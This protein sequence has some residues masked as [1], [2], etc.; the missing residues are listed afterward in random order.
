[1]SPQNRV[2]IIGLDGASLNVVLPFAQKGIMP[3][4]KHVIDRGAVGPLRSVTPPVTGPAWA[5]FLTGKQPGKHG[6]Y[7]FV[8]CVPGHVTRKP[9]NYTDIKSPTLLSLVGNAK[10]KS[11]CSFNVPIT[12]P[13]P[14]I[15]GIVVTGMLTPDTQ[16]EFTYPAELKNKLQAKYGPYILDVFWQRFSDSTAEKFVQQLMDYERQKLAIAKDLFLE[17]P[18]DLF[19]AVFTG[20]DRIQHALWHVIEAIVEGKTLSPGE[21]RLKPLVKGYYRLLDEGIADLI[22]ASDDDTIIFFMSDHGFGPLRKKFYI[23]SWLRKEGLLHYDL[24]QARRNTRKISLK[25][26]IKQHLMR[27]PGLGQLLTRPVFLP[28]KGRMQTYQF[29]DLIDWSRTQA[30]SASNTEQGIYVNLKGRQPHGVVNPGK[31]YETLRCQI[32][33]MLCGIIDPSD[34]QPLVSHIY[35]KEDIYI[36]PYTESA[37]DIVF[38]L[39]NGECLADVRLFDEL[40]QET[41]WITGRG[42]HRQDG[43]FIA[44][45]KGIRKDISVKA[46]ITDLVPIVLYLLEIPIPHEVD[47]VLPISIFKED[48]LQLRAPHYETLTAAKE[49]TV[50]EVF[51]FTDEEEKKIFQKLKGLGYMG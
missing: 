9:V 39:K 2:M 36:G 42:T 46:S 31:D 50:D 17:R 1:M 35:K 32:I 47:G 5:S 26:A 10:G 33:D 21:E 19:M 11:V 4:M 14:A 51:S 40:W 37:P 12:F 23:N 25:R 18:W 7:D 24:V 30:F 41:S 6:L 45:G 27:L 15:N 34:G 44:Y 3:Y 29:L 13:P 22:E 16:V 49:E 28:L 8:K 43:L 38:F 20:T 48:F